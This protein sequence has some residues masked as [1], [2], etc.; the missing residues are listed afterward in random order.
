MVGMGTV[1]WVFTKLTTVTLGCRDPTPQRVENRHPNTALFAA[2]RE[3]RPARPAAAGQRGQEWSGQPA[4]RD[5][6]IKRSPAL[7]QALTWMNL[8]TVRL[9]DGSQTQNVTH[10]LSSSIP[11]KCAE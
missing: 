1:Q 3:G 2:A 5:S 7:T 9:G 4:G 10:T 8:E 6:A 11:V